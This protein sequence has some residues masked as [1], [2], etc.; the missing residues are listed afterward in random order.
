MYV[1]FVLV[2]ESDRYQKH[3]HV[4]IHIVCFVVLLVYSNGLP[5]VT[6]YDVT[7]MVQH[8]FMYIIAWCLTVHYVITWTMQCY[9]LISIPLRAG[10]CSMKH[11][12]D[13]IMST[14]ASQITSLT[15]VHSTVYSRHRSERTSKLHVTGLCE[16]NS[17]V[18]SEFPAQRTSNTENVPIWWRHHEIYVK[19]D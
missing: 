11:Y 3:T 8:W 18:T 9:L 7:K 1:C 13:V 19:L 10:S 14:M 5:M 16:W 4:F 6:P 2:W 12:N 17:P 15:I